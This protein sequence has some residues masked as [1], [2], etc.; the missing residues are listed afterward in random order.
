MR[1]MQAGAPVRCAQTD[2]CIFAPLQNEC[3]PGCPENTV[4]ITFY[5]YILTNVISMCG[6]NIFTAL[7]YKLVGWLKTYDAPS[8][9]SAASQHIP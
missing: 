6:V 9:S 2:L 4:G 5:R 8:V 7:S 3:V 1:R